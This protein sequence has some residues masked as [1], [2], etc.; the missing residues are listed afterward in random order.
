MPIVWSVGHRNF[1]IPIFSD[2][3]G[4]GASLA[5]KVNRT[6][7]FSDTSSRVVLKRT[8]R[9]PLEKHEDM[10]DDTATTCVC[11]CARCK[12]SN[13]MERTTKIDG[14]SLFL[15]SFASQFGDI[16]FFFIWFV[17]VSCGFDDD[18]DMCSM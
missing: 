3:T 14:S 17:L 7:V 12:F 10:V 11:V 18:D 4:G 9:L 8:Y 16:V 2:F 15:R 6:N 5:C 13:R 1:G